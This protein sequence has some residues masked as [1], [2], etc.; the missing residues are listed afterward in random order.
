MC[1]SLRLPEDLVYEVMREIALNGD[2][3]LLFRTSVV[4]KECTR[5]SLPFARS[6]HIPLTF[7][8][9]IVTRGELFTIPVQRPSDEISSIVVNIVVD[10]GD[11][12][13]AQKY[14]SSDELVSHIYS[15]PGSYK[16]RVFANTNLSASTTTRKCFLTG[17]N[18]NSWRRWAN[19]LVSFETLGTLRIRCLRYFFAASAKFNIPIG[20]WDVSSV[21]DFN[22]LFYY[23]SSFN[24]PI[25]AWNVSSATMMESMFQGCTSFD[26]PLASWNVSAVTTMKSM[27]SDSSNFNQPLNGWNVSNVKNMDSMFSGAHMF[28]QSLRDWD[29]SNVKEVICMFYRAQTFD[30]RNIEGWKIKSGTNTVCMFDDETIHR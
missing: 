30:R 24:Q 16:V 21:K 25:G 8:Y 1:E 3:R 23:C 29:I 22:G 18:C 10:W 12:S 19:S 27:F 28:N 15:C 4:C 6:L 14:S 26:Q 2:H 13:P 20:H 11:N 17:L 5:K 9:E 7:E